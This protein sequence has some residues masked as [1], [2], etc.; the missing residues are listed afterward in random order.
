MTTAG[1]CRAAEALDARGNNFL[2]AVC[3]GQNAFGLALTDITT[4]EFRFTSTAD[5]G[6]LLDELGR[7]RPS[8]VLLPGRESR[9]RERLYKEYPLI[10]FTAVGE[11]T[12]SDAAQDRVSLEHAESLQ[13]FA[14]GIRAASA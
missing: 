1:T 8:E 10:H 7:I 4:G 6:E 5:E 12:F 2:A 11:E 14:E 13:Q 3:K 9:L